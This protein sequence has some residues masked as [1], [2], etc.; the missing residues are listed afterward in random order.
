MIDADYTHSN[1]SNSV[2]TGTNVTKFLHNDQVRPMLK[3]YDSS[4]NVMLISIRHFAVCLSLAFFCNLQSDNQRPSYR[5]MGKGLNLTTCFQSHSCDL[6]KTH[7]NIWV[8]HLQKHS[9]TTSIKLLISVK[10]HQN[11][12]I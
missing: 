6:H 5:G 3:C 2:V 1:I 11:I 7:T 9:E 12:Q 10:M 8:N 4:F